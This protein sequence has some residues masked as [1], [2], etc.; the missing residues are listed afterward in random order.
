MSD[1]R[2]G[3][4]AAAWGLPWAVAA[5]VAGFAGGC[6]PRHRPPP[7]MEVEVNSQ[8]VYEIDGRICAKKEFEIRVGALK[9]VPKT[10]YCKETTKGGRTGW[11]LT[12][13]QGRRYSYL[14]ESDGA[15]ARL[16]LRRLDEPR[17]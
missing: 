17:P 6:T 14:A 7:R 10:W 5:L 16:S 15:G 12:D 13:D 8:T 3:K 2:V 1:A 9:E 4:G 11:Q